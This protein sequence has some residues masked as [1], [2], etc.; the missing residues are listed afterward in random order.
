MRWLLER[1]DGRGGW[2]V[3]D[4]FDN[5][6]RLDEALAAGTWRSC[7]QISPVSDARARIEARRWQQLGGAA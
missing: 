2:I 5:E 6:E 4:V 1:S 7:L 3:V